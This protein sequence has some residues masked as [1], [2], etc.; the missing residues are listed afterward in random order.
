MNC[1]SCGANLPPGAAACPMCGTPTPYNVR[2]PG[3]SGPYDPTAISSGYGTPPP[4]STGYGDPSYGA[5]PSSTSPYDPYTVPSQPPPNPYTAPPPQPG[6]YGPQPNYMPPP[7]RRS[8]V[9]L[10]VGIVLLV[11]L[12]ACVGASLA[13]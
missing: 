9:W 4:P 1:S 6:G 11:L 7:R 8:R 10:I 5:P 13:I 12:L 3:S 2:G